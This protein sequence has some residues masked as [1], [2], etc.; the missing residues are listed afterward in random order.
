M[1]GKLNYR[2]S[3]LLKYIEEKNLNGLL[4]LKD[5]DIYYFT[6]FYG[7]SSR[8]ILFFI[9]KKAFLLI[10]SIFYEQ[11][12]IDVN[13]DLFTIIQYHR[14]NIKEVLNILSDYLVKQIS[15]IGSQINAE[16]SERLKTGL[17][18]QGKELVLIKDFISVFRS[19]KAKDE[20]DNIRMSCKICDSLWKKLLE[21]DSDYFLNNSELEVSVEIEKELV[22]NGSDGKSFDIIVA[23]NAHSSMPHH[24]PGKTIIKKGILQFD[25]GC[26]HN[27]YCSDISRVLFLGKTDFINKFKK[28]YGIVMEAFEKAADYCCEGITC[29]ELDSI[30]RNFIE[31]KGYGK[32]F[33][34]G[35]GHGVGLEVH[36]GPLITKNNRTVLKENMVITIEPGIYIPGLG[37][38]RIEDMLVVKKNG[39]ENLYNSKKEFTII[40]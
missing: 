15:V 13:S 40:T 9:K 14:D 32:E 30:A 7:I 18:S 8:S 2:I 10:N 36:E 35:L 38:I 5:Q 21:K 27:N 23:N 3:K 31:K 20:I 37:G 1:T 26:R 33:S 29:M 25:F 34:H 19:I 16:D 4:I 28:I 11:A 39:S 17:E 22:R 6:G 24:L 12:K